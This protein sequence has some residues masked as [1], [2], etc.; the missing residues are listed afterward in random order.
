[1]EIIGNAIQV[2]LLISI[3][4]FPILVMSK[5]YGFARVNIICIPLIWLL[6]IAAAYWPHF[7]SDFRLWLMGFNPDAV[8]GAE[9]LQSVPAELHELAMRLYSSNTGISWPVKAI[10]GSILMTPYPTLVWGVRALIK[11]IK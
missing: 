8:F 6:V 10:G 5:G 1:M 9:R 2:G 11:R 4:T 3:L 7:Y